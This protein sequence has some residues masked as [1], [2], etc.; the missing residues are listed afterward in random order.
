MAARAYA[1][2]ILPF[3]RYRGKIL[4]LIA[5]DVRDGTYSDF[6]GKAERLD[7]VD[8]R[9]TPPEATAAREF[10]EETYGL[11]LS[12][13]QL[14][15]VFSTRNYLLLMSTTRAQHPYYCYVVQV[16]FQPHLRDIIQKLLGFFRLRNVYRTFVEKTDVRWVTTAEL[17]GSL[18]KRH[19]FANTIA[20]HRAK[21]EAMEHASWR[22]VV[23]GGEHVRGKGGVPRVQFAPA[24][25]GAG[26]GADAESW[27]DA[28]AGGGAGAT[29]NAGVQQ[30]GSWREVV[31]GARG[32]ACTSAAH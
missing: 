32:R 19:V 5:E 3:T 6:G 12:E 15:A 4:W 30:A 21:L 10:L 22:D 31:V 2:G 13:Q 8:P 14:H 1:A 28:S 11:V 18:P 24:G 17:F 29:A 25:A 7:A 27:R 23:A 16:P 20:A 26:A 9:M